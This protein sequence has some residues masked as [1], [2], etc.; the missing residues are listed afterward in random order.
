V[1]RHHFLLEAAPPTCALRDLGSLNGTIVNDIKYG[2]RNP[3]ETPEDAA[4]RCKSVTL[5][6]GDY[7][8]AGATNSE[9]T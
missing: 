1:S 6:N 3:K 7:I 8:Q 4:K 2:G 5:E 9:H